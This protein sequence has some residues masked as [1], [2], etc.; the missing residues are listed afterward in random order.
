MYA[1]EYIAD[2][3]RQ[4]LPLVGGHIHDWHWLLTKWR[5]LAHAE[6]LGAA[7]HAFASVVVLG[8]LAAAAREVWREHREG[9]DGRV[10]GDVDGQVAD[11]GPI[12]D[13]ALDT[14]WRSARAIPGWV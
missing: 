7:L 4:L 1:A 6:R 9:A 3:Q 5:L 13:R 12:S 8:A 10:L 11:V 2:A 14:V